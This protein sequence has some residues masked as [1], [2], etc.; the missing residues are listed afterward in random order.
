MRHG[1]LFT[2]RPRTRTYRLLQHNIDSST[3]TPFA[4]ALMLYLFLV[5]RIYLEV[6]RGLS[7]RR[8]RQVLLR[9]MIIDF[10]F[11]L[12]HAG[13]AFGHNR[14]RHRLHQRDFRL[15][16]TTPMS[17]FTITARPP[18]AHIIIAIS[19]HERAAHFS[20]YI[21]DEYTAIARGLF[22]ALLVARAIISTSNYESLK[23]YF[24]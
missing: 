23:H 4:V 18:T 22:D 21:S 10:D 20:Y 11:T 9:T 14:G 3:T 2:N 6:R 8:Y 1:Y 15:R 7:Y 16:R 17:R 19:R 5:S 24:R 12:H 13:D